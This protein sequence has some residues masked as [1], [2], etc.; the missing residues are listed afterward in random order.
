MRRFPNPSFAC[1]TYRHKHLLYIMKTRLPGYSS[2]RKKQTP[3]VISFSTQTKKKPFIT[4]LLP[5]HACITYHHMHLLYITKTLL[6]GYNSPRKKQ[7][8]SLHFLL[9]TYKKIPFITV[10]L[11]N[12]LTCCARE[13][14]SGMKKT[15]RK[16]IRKFFTLYWILT[17][18]SFYLMK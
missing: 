15:A 17:V 18:C 9:Y 3:G 5:N 6:P 13:K 16:I 14:F 1:V 7:T 2:P 8:R 4:V 11:P 10:L 12:H